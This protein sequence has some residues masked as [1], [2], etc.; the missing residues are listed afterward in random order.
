M[1][2][3][4][5]PPPSRELDDTPTAPF[6]RSDDAALALVAETGW[7]LD[8]ASVKRGDGD[9]WAAPYDVARGFR[10]VRG[11]APD[12]AVLLPL[13]VRLRLAQRLLLNS[14]L[15]SC[16]PA[17]AHYTGRTIARTVTALRRLVSTPSP[18]GTEGA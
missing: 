11:L 7:G 16:D 3:Q 13:L 9:P 15:A 17:N 2:E 14:W 4:A 5:V 8:V 12:E 1:T 18:V 10:S 6:A